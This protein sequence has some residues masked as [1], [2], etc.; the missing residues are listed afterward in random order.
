[1]SRHIV[2]AIAAVI[3]IST[4]SYF[5]SQADQEDSKQKAF[6]GKACV[7]AGGQWQHEWGS[8]YNCLRPR[9]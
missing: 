4:I 8:N 1:V 9:T 2:W 3:A 7:E 5:V 6:L